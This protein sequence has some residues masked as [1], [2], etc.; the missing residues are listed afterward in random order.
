LPITKPVL[1]FI[2]Q[3]FNPQHAEPPLLLF[4]L[5]PIDLFLFLILKMNLPRHQPDIG[6]A[7]KQVGE[8][9]RQLPEVDR[10]M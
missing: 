8:G 4:S 1:E 9:R 6:F 2:V 5:G 3:I 7:Q 10:T